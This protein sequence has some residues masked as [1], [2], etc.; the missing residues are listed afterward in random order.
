MSPSHPDRVRKNYLDEYHVTY[1]YL[2]T[3]MEGIADI[4]DYGVISASSPE[5]ACNQIAVREEPN[6]VAW[7]LS[8]LSASKVKSPASCKLCRRPFP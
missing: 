7:M 3:G 6:H 4:R 5:D 1:Y 8:C 2:A